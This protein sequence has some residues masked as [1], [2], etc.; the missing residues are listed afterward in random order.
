M[1]VLS[2]EFDRRRSVI[3]DPP[4]VL[5]ALRRGINFSKIASDSLYLT[6]AVLWDP[7]R[8]WPQLFGTRDYM[9]CPHCGWEGNIKRDGWHSHGP[10]RVYHTDRC[11]WL[12]G[13]QYLCKTCKDA[14]RPHFYKAY[15]KKS[16][17]HLSQHPE[18]YDLS[19]V[20]LAFPVILTRK[21]AISNSTD[22]SLRYEIESTFRSW[23]GGWS[24]LE[25]RLK[26]HYI[27]RAADISLLYAKVVHANV[28]AKNIKVKSAPFL[29][30]PTDPDGMHMKWPKAAYLQNI[31]LAIHCKRRS[32]L[33][34]QLMQITGKVLKADHTFKLAKKIR[35]V[36]KCVVA[37]V[38]YL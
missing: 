7:P 13:R 2:G 10:R 36:M 16:M 24:G 5:T 28:T 35:C 29:L 38:W 8:T 32:F 4:D 11:W 33:L 27:R 30:E 9:P 6:R 22:G 25:K 12:W 21:G 17:A 31:A 34:R 15:N 23:G 37:P 19:F 14:E 20:S 3:Y 1:K 18:G 26:E